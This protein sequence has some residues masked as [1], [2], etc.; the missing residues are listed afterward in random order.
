MLLDPGLQ[1]TGSAFRKKL[2]I[3]RE[4]SQ[5][6]L[7]NV[8][9]LSKPK[10]LKPILHTIQEYTTQEPIL[11]KLR[12]IK[13]LWC[14]FFFSLG[15]I[16]WSQMSDKLELE[17]RCENMVGVSRIT[18]SVQGM[19]K[20]DFRTSLEIIISRFFEGFFSPGVSDPHP[21]RWPKGFEIGRKTLFLRGCGAPRVRRGC[22]GT[23][24]GQVSKK[25]FFEIF[26][27]FHHFWHLV[28][29]PG[30]ILG[31]SR[32]WRLRGRNIPRYEHVGGPWHLN[33][34]QNPSKGCLGQL[35]PEY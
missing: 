10:P 20:N 2:W 27:S 18:Q 1:G 34:P 24:P 14:L 31:F 3:S 33:R 32:F 8:S 12:K 26:W 16:E 13:V 35:F 6:Y 5:W 28:S 4:W 30:Q 17:K 9:W 21:I 11:A 22:V 7:P 29:D 19:S 15:W 25:L 23:I